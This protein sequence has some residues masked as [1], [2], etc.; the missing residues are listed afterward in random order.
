M[1]KFTSPQENEF[2]CAVAKAAW[3]DSFGKKKSSGKPVFA[4]DMGRFCQVERP[5]CGAGVVIGPDRRVKSLGYPSL[6][7]TEFYFASIIE[8]EL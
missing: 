8:A 1:H 7:C 4:R 5:K 2:G 6:A 3:I